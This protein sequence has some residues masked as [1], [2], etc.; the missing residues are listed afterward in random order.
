MRDP[1]LDNLASPSSSRCVKENLC[2]Q[3]ILMS[4]LI[5]PRL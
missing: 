5:L 4:P 1:A 3:I 2:E